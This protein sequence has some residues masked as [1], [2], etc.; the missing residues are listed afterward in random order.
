MRL[1][2][3]MAAVAG[4]SALYAAAFDAPAGFDF[5]DPADLD[6]WVE[7]G[8]IQEDE[9]AQLLEWIDDPLD[10][11]R[12]E[13]DELRLLPFV[14]ESLAEEINAARREK[15]FE[16]LNDLE[17]VRGLQ[18][19]LNMILPFVT[20]PS[21]RSSGRIRQRLSDTQN[22]AAP[23]Q[24]YGYLR[25]NPTPNAVVGL[26]HR[27]GGSRRAVWDADAS[28]VRPLEPARLSRGYV[29]WSGEGA[30][31]RL[32]VG[33]YSVGSGLGL[34]LN[35]ARLRYPTGARPN[36]SSLPRERGA[37]AEAR[38]GR[39]NALAFVS[40]NSLSDSLPP[41]ITGLA[42]DETVENALYRDLIG[43]RVESETKGWRF[44]AAAA[45]HRYQPK[46]GQIL[47][48]T[49]RTGAALDFD[50]R[51]RQT[52]WR[53]EAAYANAPAGW[54]EL[55]T[56]SKT[57]SARIAFYALPTEFESPR[58]SARPDRRGILAR[59]AF[60]FSSGA[61][62]GFQMNGEKQISTAVSSQSAS[63]WTAAPIG[64][65]ITAGI[66]VRWRD[67]DL[68]IDNETEWRT[69]EWAAAA[70]Q[71]W[72]VSMQWTQENGMAPS[73]LTRVDWRAVRGFVCGAR[74]KT[75]GS[76]FALRELS[77]YASLWSRGSW[78]CRPV[79]TRR[80][81]GSGASNRAVLTFDARWG[82]P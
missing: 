47:N 7:D 61:R 57:A 35:S 70:F 71:N 45:A 81:S 34:I 36:D 1:R 22:D 38:L 49:A 28:I 44:G 66:V 12:A 9:R 15:P 68:L 32:I 39:F 8:L 82:S 17:R 73:L 2:L 64:R 51:I 60:Y 33:D 40:R 54:T 67:R 50:G 19:R 24:M 42:D 58:G 78:R 18:S 72:R 3:L 31:Q 77:G 43:A 10:L 55:L 30:V 26:A 56:R 20:V 41:D 69:T 75:E 14:D 80:W 27:A 4:M 46:A 16:S 59:A 23:A 79:W 13:M 21:Y 65:I 76:R 53:G 5:V 11:N 6:E 62:I 29:A 48:E 37:A 63:A 52:R 74:V 25:L